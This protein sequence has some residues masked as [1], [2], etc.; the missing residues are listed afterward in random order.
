[1]KL[2]TKVFIAAFI[3]G[4]AFM[5]WRVYLLYPLLKTFSFHV[6]MS[7][8]KDDVAKLYADTGRGFSEE[9]S[10]EVAVFG[11]QRFHD[12]QFIL[13]LERIV[14]FRFDP[15]TAGGRVRVVRMDVVNGLGGKVRTLSL[16]SLRP[17]QQIKSLAIQDQQLTIDVEEKANDPQL[18]I[19]IDP[20]LPPGVFNRALLPFCIRMIAEF[21]AVILLISGFLWIWWRRSDW[22]LRSLLLTALLVFGWRCGVL[23]QEATMS[24][25]RVSLQ[26]SVEGQ[27]QLYYDKGK[28]FNEIDSRSAYVGLDSQYQDCLFPL[29]RSVIISAFR[30]DPLMG[31]GTLRIREMVIVNGLG[32]RLLAIDP[33]QWR[34]GHQIQEF[35]LQ[36]Y[37]VILVTEKDAND[38]QLN[39]RFSSPLVLNWSRSFMTAAFIGRVLLECLIV[40]ILTALILIALKIYLKSS[41]PPLGADM[42][43][44]VLFLLASFFLLQV[45]TR[46]KWEDTIRFV[47]AWLNG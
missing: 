35:N 12:Y 30:F 41:S 1:M 15:L 46:G 16:A 33:R 39:L 13:P 21:V 38:P 17:H 44:D 8:S 19:P 5:V 34:A 28:G 43:W 20:S 2:L 45:Y 4:A 6:V 40:G 9:N 42:F 47:R 29:P 7:S 25:L 11:D 37:E 36:N 14:H 10:S 3:M 27:A 23:Y 26:S 24:F 18:F 32:H 31:S 22:M